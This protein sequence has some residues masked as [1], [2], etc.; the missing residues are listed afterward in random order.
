[1]DHNGWSLITFGR[2]L[3]AIALKTPRLEIN[4]DKKAAQPGQPLRNSDT[5]CR[6]HKFTV[7]TLA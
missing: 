3:P 1:M 6:D 5:A 4:H 2:A 7:S